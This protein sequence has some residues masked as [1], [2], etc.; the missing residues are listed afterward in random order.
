M[1]VT[2]ES[3]RLDVKQALDHEW[4]KNPTHQRE[5]E[6]LY[7]RSIKDWKP[8]L[9]SHEEPVIV[10]LS[11]YIRG[12]GRY[13]SSVSGTVHK[14]EDFSQGAS[15]DHISESSYG[16]SQTHKTISSKLSTPSNA[17]R[18]PHGVLKHEK[19]TIRNF[20]PRAVKNDKWSQ[21]QR[22]QRLL[23]QSES[24]DKGS[25][26]AHSNS[27]PVPHQPA[28]S[29][30][31]DTS[32]CVNRQIFFKRIRRETSLAFAQVSLPDMSTVQQPPILSP[33]SLTVTRPVAEKPFKR[34]RAARDP[35]VEED[36]VYEEVQN[37]VTGKRQRR[38]YGK[39]IDLLKELL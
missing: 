14:L 36:E 26:L 32:T 11:N 4:F 35:S 24:R 18:P 30:T 25:D 19:I 20:G 16:E 15:I 28:A 39:E 21:S 23:Q 13:L 27:K 37:P 7:H 3:K 2:D 5:F 34:I 1:L 22:P 29:A 6:E 12:A 17:L 38:I 31:N 33:K 8:R 10:D 9:S